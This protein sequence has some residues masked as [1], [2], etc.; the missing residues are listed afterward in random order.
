MNALETKNISKSY[1]TFLLKNISLSLPEGC[2]M[3]LIG[4]NGAGKSTLID[5]IAGIVLPENG[6]VEVLGTDNHSKEFKEVKQ[7]IGFVPSYPCFPPLFTAEDINKV[8]REVYNKWDEELFFSYVEKFGI[9]PKKK[10]ADYSKGMTMKLPIA[11]AFSHKARLLVLD[12]ATSGLDPVARDEIMDMVNEF[13]RD[14]H[15]SV[16]MSSHILTDMEKVCDYIAYIENGELKLCEEKDILCEKYAVVKCSAKELNEIDRRYII[17]M[18]KSDFGAEALVEVSAIPLQMYR[19]R[20]NIE[21]FMV[22]TVKGREV[23]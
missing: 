7:Y 5:I 2:V 4:E 12:E 3:G 20:A 21:D 8:M 13:T 9:D 1:G 15:N 6:T 22:Y 23:Q 17:G 19:E 10:Y 16:L 14:E 11:V 18:K